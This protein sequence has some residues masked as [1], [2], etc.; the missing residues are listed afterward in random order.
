MPNVLL[1]AM[2]AGVP[3]V[4]SDCRSGPREILENGRYG[5]LVKV[6]DVDELAK[7]LL[8]LAGDIGLRQRY[9]E[10]GLIRVK[11]FNTSKIVQQW[12]EV[13]EG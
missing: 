1:E 9:A 12:I 10:Q 5:M 13:I 3:V 7:A 11:D 2:A 4:A 6:G 8:T